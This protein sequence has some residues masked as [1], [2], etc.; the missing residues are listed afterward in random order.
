MVEESTCVPFAM[1]SMQEDFVKACEVG[2]ERTVQQMLD[3][4]D[5]QFESVYDGIVAAFDNDK[6]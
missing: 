3:C 6:R 2:D 1:R 4:A 5:F